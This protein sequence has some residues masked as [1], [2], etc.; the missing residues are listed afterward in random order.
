MRTILRIGT[1]LAAIACALPM[2]ITPTSTFARLTNA[3]A[4]SGQI[5]GQLEEAH[6]MIG[7]GIKDAQN[8]A[9]GR[10]EDAVV[11]LE[12]GRILY[13]VAAINGMKDK[14]ALPSELFTVRGG[15][16]KEHILNVDKEKLNAAPKFGSEQEG[17]LANASFASEVYKAFGTPAWWESGGQ[18][19]GSFNNAHKVS[20]LLNSSVKNVANAELGKVDEVILD[21]HSARVPYV[22]LKRQNAYAIP[23]NAFTLAGDKHTIVTGLDVNVLS[24]APQ[25]TK[26]NPQSLANRATATA[27]Y[28][29]YGKQPYFGEGLAPTGQGTNNYV[30]PGK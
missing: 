16:T 22:V 14:V 1:R 12:S 23:S 28:R 18:A 8:Q 6:H 5:I 25:Y 2:V 29:H 26:G 27:I 20:N 11:D 9:L 24:S 4:V 15:A 21:L 19:G 13:T 17:Q 30:Y 10:I 3:P 7:S